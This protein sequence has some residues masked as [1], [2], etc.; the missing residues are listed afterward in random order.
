LA[1]SA[2]NLLCGHSDNLS[3][4]TGK[5]KQCSAELKAKVA[6]EARRGELTRAQQ[7]TK[8]GIHQTMVAEWKKQAMDGLAAVFSGRSEA[9]LRRKRARPRWRSC[10]PRSASCWWGEILGESLRSMSVERRRQMIE[11][12]HPGLSVS[13]GTLI[14]IRDNLT[15]VGFQ[16]LGLLDSN[17]WSSEPR[18]LLVA[19]LDSRC[20][21]GSKIG[22]Y[23]R[24]AELRS[25]RQRNLAPAPPDL[26]GRA[27]LVRHWGRL[28]TRG[29][30]CLDPHPD[31]GA[32]V[33][34]LARLLHAKSLRGYQDRAV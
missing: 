28:G 30:R 25:A 6:L 24:H 27:L 10:T 18:K 5:P 16:R 14:L 7:A 17:L 12:D 19:A 26:L 34:A 22:P 29:R 23:L 1:P 21:F 13:A 20:D 32:A 9:E 15:P 31:P 2:I 3:S 33:N 4:V 8:H 11:P